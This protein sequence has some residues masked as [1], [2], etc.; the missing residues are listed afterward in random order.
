MP[1]TSPQIGIFGGSFNPVH[2]GHIMLASWLVQFTDLDAVW[3]MLSPANPLKKM[4]EGATDLNR[5]EM[6]QAAC[7]PFDRIKPCDIE[8]SMP[9]PSYTIDSLNRLEQIH[10]DCRFRLVVGSDNWQIFDRWK[11]SE[12]IIR[13]FRPIVYPRPGYPI[14]HTALPPE[15]TAVN[16]PVIE[17]SS[18][19]IRQSLA[20]G[21]DMRA[22]LPPGVADYI[23]QHELYSV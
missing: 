15:V 10:P 1:D 7:Q 6:L 23:H 3:L 8:L 9:H 14:D 4:A 17:I 16:A 5:L 13:R 11:E 20:D 12:E 2:I 18:T 19:F 22:F 21:L